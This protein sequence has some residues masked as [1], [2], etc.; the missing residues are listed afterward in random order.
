MVRDIG[1][2]GGRGDR[3]GG[4]FGGGV[5]IAGRVRSARCVA[6]LRV[7]RRRGHVLRRVRRSCARPSACVLS[8]S[9]VD[10]GDAALVLIQAGD[11]RAQVETVVVAVAAGGCGVGMALDGAVR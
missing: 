3:G 10:R 2:G 9:V 1:R 4:E 7:R 8:S 6:V 5:R 11:D